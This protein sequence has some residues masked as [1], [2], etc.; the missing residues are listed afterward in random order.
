M[1]LRVDDNLKPLLFVENPKLLGDNNIENFVKETDLLDGTNTE[2]TKK[3][4]VQ[5][6][7]YNTTG[8]ANGT[9][10][11]VAHHIKLQYFRQEDNSSSPNTVLKSENY[12]DSAFGGV[13]IPALNITTAFQHL[14]N[15]KY[16]FINGGS[17]SYVADNG[18]YQD[19][20]LILFYADNIYPLISSGSVFPKVDINKVSYN[21]IVSSP[22][23]RQ[24]LLFNKWQI[25]EG[26]TSIDIL[27]IV[28]YNKTVQRST[29]TEDL[30]FLGL[31][32]GE[33]N[34]LDNLTGVSN[35]HHKYLLFEEIF[36]S[37]GNPLKDSIT[38]TVYK[39]FKLKIQGFDESGEVQIVEPTTGNEIYVYGSTYYM[40]CTKDFT[41]AANIDRILPDPGTFTE[42]QNYKHIQFDSN[43][44]IVTTLFPT[45]EINI[46]DSGL[47]FLPRSPRTLKVDAGL[48]GEF[49]YP[50]DSPG[51][52][53]LSTRYAQ[54]PLVVICHGN[55]QRYSDYREL[56]I[57]LSK[58]GF[59]VMSISALL[60]NSVNISP[61]Y[62]I[63]DIATSLVF[64]TSFPTNYFI[65]FGGNLDTIYIYNNDPGTPIN[66]NYAYEKLTVIKGI[67][68]SSVTPNTFSIS[69]EYLL[70][71]E[72]GIDFDVILDSTGTPIELNFLVK[73]GEHD[74]SILGRSN[75][76]Y[77]HLQ[78]IRKYFGDKGWGNKIENKIGLIGHSR[79]AEAVVRCATDIPNST[80][81]PR[82]DIMAT[83]D[84]R[85]GPDFW[86]FVPIDLFDIKAVVSLAPTDSCKD[87]INQLNEDV[88]YYVLYGSM[89][90]DVVGNPTGVV[91]NRTSGFSIYDRTINNTEKIMSFVYGATHNGF[92][93]NNQDY[94]TFLSQTGLPDTYIGELE[95]VAIQKKISLAYMNAFMR[96][97]LKDENIWKSIFYGD[98]IPKST[99]SDKIYP[100][101]QNLV[102][103]PLSSSKWL[104]NFDTWGSPPYIKLNGVAVPASS[105]DDLIN[106]NSLTPHDA[107]GIKISI[108]KSRISTLAF[109]VDTNGKDISSYDFL[110]FRIG[111]VVLGTSYADLSKIEIN[112]SSL[113]ASYKRILN[114]T[115]PVPHQRESMLTKSAMSTIRLSLSDFSSNGIDLT[116]IKSLELIFPSF[117]SDYEILMDD[118]EFTN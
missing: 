53:D 54:F 87:K 58:N 19:D 68:D 61:M 57:H 66:S 13:H 6:P 35:L 5:Y 29:P 78:I 104:V 33:L 45:G 40:L 63:T 52:S 15:N 114:K 46:D 115:I 86:K 60:Y 43:D 3:V 62:Q 14:K 82:V 79:G 88:P 80:L 113:S 103:P 111:H 72:K 7:N 28:G 36:D 21:P 17:F 70:S 20:S 9:K 116:K 39:K 27:E 32:K 107:K 44:P 99:M 91:P 51:S 23:F 34:T 112:L 117:P 76:I 8:A 42:F 96:L 97:Y 2:W 90:G 4:K 118:I 110:S 100:Q 10:L 12:L 50:I 75:M 22:L 47:T 92:I 83:P 59:I 41:A 94:Y 65:T 73:I 74:M 77:P 55:G 69:D 98:Y 108:P 26:T 95:S 101:Y 93:T 1:Q 56:A 71:F 24:D 38:N 16:F 89:E 109:E 18:I 106:L 84:P 31:T 37:S 102:T 64:S 85:T 105:I 30:L 11:D 25:T 48:N 67:G 81:I 49:F